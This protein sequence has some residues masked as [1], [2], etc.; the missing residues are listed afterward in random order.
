MGTFRLDRNSL[1]LLLILAFAFFLR[2]W[3]VHFGL[4][5]AYHADEPIVIHHALAYGSGDLNPHFFNIPP[6]VSYLLFA[7]GYLAFS[8]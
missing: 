8:E 3:G 2:I 1:I 4:P 7:L 6:L 5:Y